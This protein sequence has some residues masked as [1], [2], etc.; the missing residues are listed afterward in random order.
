MMFGRPDLR[1]QETSQTVRASSEL[2]SCI[3]AY[4]AR[5]GTRN[6]LWAAIRVLA[7]TGFYP[8]WAEGE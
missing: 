8:G 6:R 5:D 1:E 4:E 3:D 2:A 7:E